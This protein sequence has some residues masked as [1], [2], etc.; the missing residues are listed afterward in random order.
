VG[1]S[2]GR[3]QARLGAGTIGAGCGPTSERGLT[4]V[5]LLITVAVLGLALTALLGS[6]TSTV[7]VSRMVDGRSTAHAE[8]RR[9]GETIRSYSTPFPACADAVSEYQ[10]VLDG[11][12]ATGFTA[13]VEAVEWGV[14]DAEG[15][16]F[17]PLT[18]GGTPPAIHRVRITVEVDGD[19]STDSL[20]V[21]KRDPSPAS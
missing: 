18:C 12:V 10:D 13:T 20:R 2:G 4:L 21:V 5:E 11:H 14:A 15:V 17:S 9:L 19:G 7:L 3:G 6:V 8:A 16:A 1:K